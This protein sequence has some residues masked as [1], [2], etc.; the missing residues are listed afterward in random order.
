MM[1]NEKFLHLVIGSNKMLARV[2]PR[3][4]A[5][6]G[7]E[8]ELIID[9]DRLHI[10]DPKSQLAIDRISIPPEIQEEVSPPALPP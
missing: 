8:Y 5:K 2:D 6:Q 9:V 3:T 4:K 7:R 10:F 1:G